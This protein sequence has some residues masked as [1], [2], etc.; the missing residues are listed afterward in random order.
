MC[1][2]AVVRQAGC[3]WASGARLDRC[4]RPHQGADGPSFALRAATGDHSVHIRHQCASVASYS[5]LH[6]HAQH[7]LGPITHSTLG[8]PKQRSSARVHPRRCLPA[9]AY[10]PSWS[11]LPGEALSSRRLSGGP[12]PASASPRQPPAMCSPLRASYQSSASTV[13]APDA[14]LTSSGRADGKS[15]TRGRQT[16]A[17]P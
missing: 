8:H 7:G 15:L 9:L 6:Q 3:V 14:S 2:R 13:T 5:P 12:T 11:G 10:R 1:S 17:R 4:V 16:C